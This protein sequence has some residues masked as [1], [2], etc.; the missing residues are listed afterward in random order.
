MEVPRCK[1]CGSVLEPYKN[2]EGKHVEGVYWHTMYQRLRLKGCTKARDLLRFDP[3]D[4][5][6]STVEFK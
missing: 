3:S 2:Q 4:L 5:E 6:N 1:K